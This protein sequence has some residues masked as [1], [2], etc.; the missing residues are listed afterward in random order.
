MA[1]PKYE[2]LPC[3]KCG[4]LI[5]TFPP[6]RASHV[7]KCQGIE[8]DQ[9]TPDDQT[10]TKTAT[11]PA[12]GAA[13][14]QETAAPGA[15]A[16][17]PTVP[18]PTTAPQADVKTQTKI[19]D[20]VLAKR[21]EVALDAQNRFTEAPQLFV[22]E[23]SSD[24]FMEYRKIYLPESIPISDPRT[25]QVLRPPQ[26]HEYFGDPAEANTDVHRG[27]VP[28]INEHGEQVTT[29]SGMLMYRLDQRL[30]D[31]RVG[32]AQRESASLT[33]Q[34]AGDDMVDVAAERHGNGGP[35]A[36]GVIVEEDSTTREAP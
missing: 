20:P 13:S 9:V 16:P 18:A 31:A 25:G 33:K 29:T 21:M 12:N 22:S 5:T 35:V 28:I 3:E 7:N 32:S 26:A 6:A 30:H 24:E 8:G 10:T 11:N 1:E 23:N 34:K 27:Y 19:K 4:K 36:D 15:Q 14:A 17:A 2:K